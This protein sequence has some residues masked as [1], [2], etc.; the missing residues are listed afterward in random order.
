[1]KRVSKLTYT[2]SPLINSS[3]L[4]CN[5]LSRVH[6]SSCRTVNC[7]STCT[8]GKQHSRLVSCCYPLTASTAVGLRALAVNSCR[9]VGTAVHTCPSL[10]TAQQHA[11]H[12]TAQQHNRGMFKLRSKLQHPLGEFEFAA[13]CCQVVDD[14]CAYLPITVRHLHLHLLV[15]PEQDIQTSTAVHTSHLNVS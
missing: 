15:V 7:S 5:R 14:C 1:M 10:S 6:G 2:L 4:S 8:A 13:N 9:M 3:G 12:T 11:Q